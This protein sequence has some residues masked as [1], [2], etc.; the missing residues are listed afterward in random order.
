[1]KLLYFLLVGTL[2]T[3]CEKSEATPE[4]LVAVRYSQTQ[5]ADPW[6]NPG[7]NSDQ[8]FLE[9]ATRYVQQRG[10]Q[11]YQPTVKPGNPAVCA[12]CTCP[13]GRVLEAR[14]ASAD[15]AALAAMGFQH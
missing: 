7:Q 8:G 14:A 1:M 11:L 12:A 3:G 6:A 9:A 2:A 10:I 4:N 5:C 15:V 13:T